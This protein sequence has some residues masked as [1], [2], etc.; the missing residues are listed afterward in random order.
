MLKSED[1]EKVN[2]AAKDCRCKLNSAMLHEAHDAT[3]LINNIQTTWK[4]IQNQ[5]HDVVRFWTYCF[6]CDYYDIK[7]KFNNGSIVSCYIDGDRLATKLSEAIDNNN[8]AYTEKEIEDQLKAEK[9]FEKASGSFIVLYPEERDYCKKLLSDHGY[10][11]KI[12]NYE[13]E[14]FQFNYW[15]DNKEQLQEM[16][17]VERYDIEFI[18]EG[19][20]EDEQHCII[21]AKSEE[22]AINRFISKPFNKDCFIL[23]VVPYK[24]SIASQDLGKKFP[25]MA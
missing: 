20:G 16:F 23:R 2:Q 21:R 4:I 10:D 7:I 17:G 19:S 11:Y 3:S 12:T 13:D 25:L 24:R 8:Y 6:L 18:D 22:D 14:S 1:I 9:V 15:K 5:F